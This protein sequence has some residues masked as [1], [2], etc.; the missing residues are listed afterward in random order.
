MKAGAIDKT[1]PM[2]GKMSYHMCF[3][4]KVIL[5]LTLKITVL[6][7]WKSWVMKVSVSLYRQF[8]LLGERYLVENEGNNSS[9][10]TTSLPVWQTALPG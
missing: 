4:Y 7:L 9:V 1:G 2:T 8:H 5:F 10:I 6:Y 3:S